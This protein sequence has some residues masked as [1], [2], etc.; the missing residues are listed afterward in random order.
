MN[1]KGIVLSSNVC[2]FHT[3]VYLLL[4]KKASSLNWC[5]LEN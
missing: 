4:C 2:M 3:I 5:I 1:D